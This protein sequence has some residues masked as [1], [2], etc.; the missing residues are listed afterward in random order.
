M[1]WQKRF[2]ENNRDEDIEN[3]I[4]EIAEKH[5]GNYGYR[6]INLE[7]RKYGH[8]V[9]HKKVLRITNKLGITCTKFTRKSRKFSTYKGTVGKIAKN[10]IDRRFYTNVPYQKITT[11]TTEFKYYE[12]NSDGQMIIKKAYLDPFLDMFNG[13]ILSFR[14]S[15]KPNAKAILD[16]LDEAIE[17]SKACPY[18][19]TIHSDQGWGY[20]M[21]AF[22]KKLKDN[23]I[24]QSMSRRG[25]CLDNSPMENFFGL[26]KQEMYH[27]EIYHSFEGLKQAIIKYIFYYNNERIKSKLTGM[28]PIEYRLHTSQLA[29]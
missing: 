2:N 13:E 15:E 1:Y 12:T 26:M 21:K 6:R 9:N 28:S 3:L 5:N 22:T 19:R 11:D 24:F 7:L 25:N 16:A 17:V 18:R 29:A 23:N 8:A 20:Q 14:L 27:G 10:L 4:K